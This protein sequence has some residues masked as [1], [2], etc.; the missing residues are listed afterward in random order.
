MNW[1]HGLGV[2]KNIRNLN[3]VA[4]FTFDRNETY[5]NIFDNTGYCVSVMEIDFPPLIIINSGLYYK[6]ESLEVLQPALSEIEVSTRY[7]SFS[8]G[9]PQY[10]A[11]G[12]SS[13]KYFPNT[14][15]QTSFPHSI[16]NGSTYAMTELDPEYLDLFEDGNYAV[17]M[18]ISGFGHTNYYGQLPYYRQTDGIQGI[19]GMGYASVADISGVANYI[20]VN[21]TGFGYTID[22]NEHEY[23][24]G[25]SSIGFSSTST[26]LTEPFW[27]TE[28]RPLVD[29]DMTYYYRSTY[30]SITNMKIF[31]FKDV[32]LYA[33]GEGEG[34]NIFILSA[35]NNYFKIASSIYGSIVSIFIN[36]HLTE[37]GGLS[38]DI[39]ID[40]N[41]VVNLVPSRLP[42]PNTKLM[43]GVNTEWVPANPM[44]VVDVDFGFPLYQA[45]SP[46]FTI[47]MDN[48]GLYNRHLLTD[49]IWNIYYTNY[50]YVE[51]FRRLGFTQLYDFS[52]LY[53]K[54]STRYL[55]NL[56]EIP[57]LITPNASKL[58]V[59]VNTNNNNYIN[60]PYV[61]R[62]SVNDYE[63]VLK[64][65]NNASIKSNRNRY[66]NDA[67]SIFDSKSQLLTFMFRTTDQNGLL[68]ANTLYNNN[69]NN[70]VLSIDDGNLTLFAE[71]AVRT[72]ISGLADG[73][74][75]NV[76]ITFG[77]PTRL[78]IDSQ[79]Y[80]VSARQTQMANANTMFANGLPGYNS[81]VVDIALI[82]V[83]N[84]LFG[85]SA[86]KLLIETTKVAYIARGQITL[87]NIAVNTFVFVY[88]R[89]TGELIDKI[90]TSETDGTFIYTNRRP[91][92]IT[93]VVNDT[94]LQIGRSYIVDPVELE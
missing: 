20:Y 67:Y 30:N 12:Y 70:I 7:S 5:V 32:E 85:F 52:Q 61:I 37:F 83:S 77:G 45:K 55:E 68:F 21:P 65:T 57:N 34:I 25:S 11:G 90:I 49:E 62:N 86:I 51:I 59:S 41:T 9:M 94:T 58:F 64:L 74:W 35:N 89:Q 39:Y 8:S 29:I 17:G 84:S 79:L 10:V 69:I 63:Y 75:H 1:R 56:T 27:Q 78:Y 48:V 24:A 87:N 46:N 18:Q 80:Y 50:H 28:P 4:L 60:L 43:V 54:D 73:E 15:K 44:N 40:D 38:Y 33:V 88:N 6:G 76:I 3:P 36:C 92:T 72:S 19:S 22:I 23:L 82:G 42:S 81:L 2:H 26:I 53:Q 91:F 47:K 66:S 16:N 14:I 93:I 31:S 13:N 71:N